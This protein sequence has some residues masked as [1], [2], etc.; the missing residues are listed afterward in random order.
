[1]ATITRPLR[2]IAKRVLSPAIA[3][4]TRWHARKCDEK[5]S[6]VLDQIAKADLGQLRNIEFVQHQIEQIGLAR[7]T[8]GIYGQ[9]ERFMNPIPRGF[10]QIPRQLAEFSVLLSGYDIRSF[11]EVG[12]FTGYTFAFLTAYLSRFNREFLAITIDIKDWNSVKPVVT[13][14]YNAQFVMGT[15]A[16]YAGREFDLCLI[17]GDHSFDAVSA[18]FERIGRKAK[19]CAF[20]DINDKLVGEYPPNNGGVPRFWRQLKAEIKDR[21]F[22]EFLYQSRNDTVMGIGVAVSSR[23]KRRAA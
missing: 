3:V 14:R 4:R 23:A 8:R 5:L 19:L 15:S 18:D 7:D 16:D 9:D 11:V 22:H 20:H 2:K 13:S 1:M 6:A 17:D 12:T 10:W 21:E